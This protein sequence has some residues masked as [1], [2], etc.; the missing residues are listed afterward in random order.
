MMAMATRERPTRARH[1]ATGLDACGM[2]RP[3]KH[4]GQRI[5]PACRGILE[6]GEVHAGRCRLLRRRRADLAR[7]RRPLP[8]GRF[9]HQGRGLRPAR[10]GRN[11]RRRPLRRRVDI[12][13]AH[14]FAK[15][16]EGKPVAVALIGGRL[17]A[18]WVMAKNAGKLSEADL[19]E[20][21]RSNAWG[22]DEP[23]GPSS[24]PA[25]CLQAA[26]VRRHRL[27]QGRYRRSRLPGPQFPRRRVRSP[28]RARGPDGSLHVRRAGRHHQHL[29]GRVVLC[30]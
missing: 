10:G 16:S 23:G 19:A 25:R 28:G 30:S 2:G 15:A 22:A 12:P 21:L 9:R 20:R 3:E 27:P 4:R 18:H 5:C 14:P 8:G 11:P 7:L 13:P 6:R 26:E 24:L 1:V 17:S 29:P